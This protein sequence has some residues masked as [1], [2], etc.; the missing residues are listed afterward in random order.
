MTAEDVDRAA[1]VERLTIAVDALGDAVELLGGQR[2]RTPLRVV[3]E[4][5]ANG[6]SSCA[7]ARHDQESP[8]DTR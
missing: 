6:A 7:F 1:L 4:D 8:D 3:T 5:Q 2:P